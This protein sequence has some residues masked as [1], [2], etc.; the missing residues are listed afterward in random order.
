MKLIKFHWV[1]ILFKLSD[2]QTLYFSQSRRIHTNPGKPRQTQANSGKFWKKLFQTLGTGF[3]HA[4]LGNQACHH[5]AR[6][7]IKSIIRGR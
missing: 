3:T 7:D 4:A 1:K 5:A 2:L 6:R